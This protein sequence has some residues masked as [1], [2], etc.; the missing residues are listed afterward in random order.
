VQS[1]NNLFTSRFSYISGFQGVQSMEKLLFLNILRHFKNFG[2]CR[3][4]KNYF[5]SIFS[6]I[7]GYYPPD[8]EIKN[9]HL[10]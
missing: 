4:W 6:Y 10:T 7:S 5:S 8:P 1:V 3:A 9:I 2:G